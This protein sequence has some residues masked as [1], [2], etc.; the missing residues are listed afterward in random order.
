MKWYVLQV[1]PGV[2]KEVVEALKR[3]GVTLFILSNNRRPGSRGAA[4]PPASGHLDN[5]AAPAV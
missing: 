2:D 3:H 1:K 4:P 5:R